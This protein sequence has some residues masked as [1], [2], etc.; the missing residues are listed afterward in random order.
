MYT[1]PLGKIPSRGQSRR[2]QYVQA[3]LINPDQLTAIMSQWPAGHLALNTPE[4][5]LIVVRKSSLSTMKGDSEHGSSLAAW[6]RTMVT[7]G[8][9]HFYPMGIAHFAVES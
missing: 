1:A 3:R 8:S 5:G 4:S 6:C 7:N 2:E 9:T